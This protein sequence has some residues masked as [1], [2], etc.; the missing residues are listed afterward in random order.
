MILLENYLGEWSR[1]QDDRFVPTFH[2]IFGLR[3]ANLLELLF[4]VFVLPMI[5]A[6]G[7]EKTSIDT[8]DLIFR[9]LS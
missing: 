1:F 7:G 6:I 5:S 3:D 8:T 4:H 9:E 2:R